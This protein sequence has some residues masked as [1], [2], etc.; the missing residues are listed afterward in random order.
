MRHNT[1]HIQPR[2]ESYKPWKRPNFTMT[3]D[4]SLTHNT[5]FS[6]VV[7]DT[8]LVVNEDCYHLMEVSI[9]EARSTSC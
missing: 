7:M 6:K 2:T 1:R 8:D 4:S 3:T 9:A 5:D